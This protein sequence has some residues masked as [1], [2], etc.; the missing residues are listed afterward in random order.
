[1]ENKN[2]CPL[3]MRIEKEKKFTAKTQLQKVQ[4]HLHLLKISILSVN[5]REQICEM[6]F[7]AKNL[8]ES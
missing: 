1:M 7:N 6:G 4:F 8:N 2:E 5:M 3:K